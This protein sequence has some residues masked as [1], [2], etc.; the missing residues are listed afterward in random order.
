MAD[1]LKMEGDGSPQNVAFKLLLQIKAFENFDLRQKLLDAYA[2]CL[3]AAHGA[4]RKV[5]R[6]RV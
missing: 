6:D 3:D 2:E 1:S 5:Q 4:R